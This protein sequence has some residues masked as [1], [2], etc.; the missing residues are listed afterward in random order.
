MTLISKKIK[1][2][3]IVLSIFLFKYVYAE[4]LKSNISDKFYSNINEFSQNLA[5][6][7]SD[8]LSQNENIKYFDIT[9]DIKENRKPSFE[10][11]S[12]NKISE[13]SDSAIFNQTNII[14]HDGDTTINLGLGKRKLLNN[15]LLM[16]GGNAFL[17]RQ[18]GSEAHFRAGLGAEAIS[19]VFDLRANYYNAISGWEFTDEGKE[20]ALDGYDLQLNYHLQDIT[21]TDLYIQTFEWENPNSTFKEKGEKGG[22]TSKIGNFAFEAGYLNNNKNNDGFFGSIKLVIPLGEEKENTTTENIET[23]SK[24]V[25]VKDKLYIP[26]KRE[27]KIRVVKIASGVKVSGF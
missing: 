15:D 20:K 5:Q 11:L 10:I 24:Y 7:L 6:G 8:T 12:V 4:D 17:D 14:S 1:I 25:S 18:I 22:I 2:S 3:L 16:L 9:V 21:N 27:N 13:D 26:V 23:N 19:S